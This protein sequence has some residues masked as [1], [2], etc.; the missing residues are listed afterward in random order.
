MAYQGVYRRH[1]T[2]VVV[3]DYKIATETYVKVGQ[4]LA[5]GDLPIHQM[6]ALFRRKIIGK[7]GSPWVDEMLA[8]EKPVKSVEKDD[9]KVEKKPRKPRKK[10]DRGIG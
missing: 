10:M 8:R 2:H 9:P 6:R 4:K 1:E 7:E 5:V 3:K